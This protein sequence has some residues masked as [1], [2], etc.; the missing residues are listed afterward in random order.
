MSRK[1]SSYVSRLKP[2]KAERFLHLQQGPNQASAVGKALR[3][4]QRQAA[5]DAV[6]DVGALAACLL[7]LSGVRLPGCPLWTAR[8]GCLCCR[9]SIRQFQAAEA[10][11]N[12]RCKGIAR[13]RLACSRRCG[14][15]LHMERDMCSSCLH[16][17]TL[18]GPW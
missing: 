17:N 11:G 13:P 5:A 10:A 16:A 8:Q 6:Q 1:S 3:H 9:L 14:S 4:L 15:I 2:A 12:D 18:R 7:W